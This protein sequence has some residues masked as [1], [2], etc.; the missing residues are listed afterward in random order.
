LLEAIRYL[1]DAV[2]GAAGIEGIALRY[3]T[4]WSRSRSRSQ[5]GTL[6]KPTTRW[7]EC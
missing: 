3:A 6:K 7:P 2:I 1:E 4:T 5:I